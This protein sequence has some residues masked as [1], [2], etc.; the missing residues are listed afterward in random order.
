MRPVHQT[1]SRPPLTCTQGKLLRELLSPGNP[2]AKCLHRLPKGKCQHPVLHKPCACMAITGCQLWAPSY[3]L[4]QVRPTNGCRQGYGQPGA[5]EYGSQQPYASQYPQQPWH[6]QESSGAYE[7]GQGNHP[8]AYQQEYRPQQS[9]Y[10]QPQQ[11]G[12][13]EMSQ[14]TAIG[15]PAVYGQEFQGRPSAGP[16]YRPRAAPTY[17]QPKN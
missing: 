14:Q 10:S 15:Y 3:K 5:Q 17:D 12:S 2:R 6:A 16:P 1:M 4:M 8:N 7:Q 11:Y 13:V 9:P